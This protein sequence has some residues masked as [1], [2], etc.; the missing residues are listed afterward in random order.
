M[1]P[2]SEKMMGVFIGGLPGSIKGNV[3]ASKPQTLEEAI[4]IT[5]RNTTN[6]NNYPNNRINNYQNNN[7]NRNNDHHQQHNRRQE[8]VRAYAATPTKNYGALQK[9]VPK[10]KQQ[11]PG[12]SIHA[13]GQERSPR[14]ERSHGFDVVIG[15]DW[16]SKYHAK[17]L[18]DEKVVHIPSDGETLIIRVAR[19][20]YRLAPS[21]MQEL[22][23]QLQELVDRGKRELEAFKRGDDSF[24][25]AI[26]PKRGSTQITITPDIVV[27]V[28]NIPMEDIVTKMSFVDMIVCN[29]GGE[30]IDE[31][32]LSQFEKEVTEWIKA[33]R[34]MIAEAKESPGNQQKM[35]RLKDTI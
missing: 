19:A 12:K 2:N 17:I 1:V 21:E 24:V 35:Q 27:N 7:R 16:L 15:M 5:Q 13:E 3:T 20:L 6:N 23:D 26:M 22:S 9:L 25:C 14:S 28:K 32:V 34:Q 18:C 31:G 4:T 29:Q 11:C 33:T 30:R 8:A 10:S